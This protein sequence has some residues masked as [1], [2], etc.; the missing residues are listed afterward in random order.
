M[1]LQAALD[2]FTVESADPKERKYLVVR[3]KSSSLVTAFIKCLLGAKT[4]AGSSTFG[5][6]FNLPNNLRGTITPTAQ[7]LPKSCAEV[8]S[9]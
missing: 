6:L 9:C 5:I 2:A 8:S 3:Q 1:R 4:C 7:E